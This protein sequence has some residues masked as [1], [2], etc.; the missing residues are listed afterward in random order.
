[1]AEVV[2]E[3]GVA[4]YTVQTPPSCPDM[5]TAQ[6]YSYSYGQYSVQH[7]R[8]LT[9]NWLLECRGAPAKILLYVYIAIKNQMS[10]GWVWG[11]C[12][13]LIRND[14]SKAIITLYLNC[15]ILYLIKVGITLFFH[16]H[17]SIIQCLLQFITPSSVAR[18]FRRLNYCKDGTIEKQK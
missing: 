1:M 10:K 8:K 18:I 14:A 4:T 15:F 6:V 2:V 3:V 13:H 17:L 5:L 12:K 7:G 16:V 11:L 9:F